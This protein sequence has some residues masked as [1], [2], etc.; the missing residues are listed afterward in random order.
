MLSLQEYNSKSKEQSFTCYKVKKKS[1]MRWTIDTFGVLFGWIGTLQLMFVI[2]LPILLDFM[3][4][5]EEDGE[6]PL[7]L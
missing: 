3:K 6:I 4:E 1:T 7:D 5:V 2:V